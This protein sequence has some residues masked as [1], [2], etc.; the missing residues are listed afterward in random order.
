MKTNH[1]VTSSIAAM[2]L[3][4]AL[5]VASLFWSF[6]QIK[7]AAEARKHINS[8]LNSG[9]NL[10][11]ALKDAE[12]G[13]RGYLLTGDDAFLEPYLAVR[14]T[15]RVDLEKL[16]QITQYVPAKKNLDALAQLID[17]K[18]TYLFH[19]IELRRNNDMT[20]A[21]ANLRGSQGK[22]LMD[23]IRDRMRSFILAE[24]ATSEKLDKEFRSNMSRMFVIII[25]VS[26]FSVVFALSF[27]YMIYR[28]TTLRLK[29]L[30]HS[31]TQHLLEIQEDTNKQLQQANV[32]LRDSE[33]RL[34]VTLS[35]IGDAV[36]TTDATALV[37]S[38]NP[39]AERLTGWL[40]A[41]ATGR[42]VDDI[43]HIINK[44]T[45][46]PAAI[47]IMAALAH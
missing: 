38:L 8:V 28:Q 45:R 12:T 31:E 27:A 34:A 43:F 39:V 23:T 35:S 9:H 15:V 25:I 47:P 20:A 21:L 29:N 6:S 37:T 32:T 44:D 16:R 42:P 24:E 18:M 4:V 36:I 13:Y 41:E 46:K 5:T 14:D 1:N 33:E 26:F 17:A 40:L 11:S 22:E 30:V 19:N 10:L 3:M 7:E 2:A